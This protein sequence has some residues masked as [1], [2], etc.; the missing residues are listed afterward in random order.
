MK[1]IHWLLIGIISLL[2]SS[3]GSDD[4]PETPYMG[5]WVI[6]Y[7][8]EYRYMHNDSPEFVEWFNAH[9]DC[10]VYCKFMKGNAY[11]E[12]DDYVEL[13]DYKNYPKGY[14]EWIEIIDKATEDEIKLMV[15]RFNDFTIIDEKSQLHY[16]KFDAQYQKYDGK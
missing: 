9:L 1:T 10:F 11:Y 3:C 8:E 15:A 16:D 2:A 6:D 13:D 4:E 7:I 12:F 5:P 14:I